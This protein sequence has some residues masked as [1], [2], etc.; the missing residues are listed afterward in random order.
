[1]KTLAELLDQHGI[2]T[3]AE[4]LEFEEV[5]NEVTRRHGA[6]L[7]SAHL[8]FEKSLADKTADFDHELSVAHEEN[9]AL[10]TELAALREKTSLAVKTA[11]EAINDTA[12]DDKATLA[13]LSTVISD[14]TKD[15]R[16]RA[17]EALEASI[18]SQQEQ[19]AAIL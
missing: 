15:D 12:L 13:V 14:V 7:Q 3:Y 5:V 2:S 18:K 10:Q 17:R 1:M 11:I 16:Q 6:E 8:N 4:R 9:A 19:L